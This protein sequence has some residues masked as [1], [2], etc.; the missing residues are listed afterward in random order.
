VSY[1]ARVLLY[2]FKSV[3]LLTVLVPVNVTNRDLNIGGRI[4]YDRA[5]MIYLVL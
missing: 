4:K 3:H 2:T 5:S 1:V